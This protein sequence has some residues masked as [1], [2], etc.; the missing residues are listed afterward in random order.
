MHITM[1]DAISADGKL[2]RHGDPNLHA[3]T[4]S[5]DARHFAAMLAKHNLLVM[6]RN[7]YEVAHS[8][9]QAERLRVVITQN[10]QQYNAQAVKGQLE[11][12]DE[13]PQV[14]VQRLEAAG[15]KDML[16]LGGGNLNGQFV[17]AG[18]I[19]ELY[20][21][22]EPKLFG[23]GTELLGGQAVDQHLRLLEL[24][25]LN[26]EGTLLAHYQFETSAPA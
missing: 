7:T 9:P 22:I 25:K 20:L 17:A 23:T 21:T 2:T 19:T 3:W 24:T 16:L 5:E 11:F 1:I 4:S 26:N 12:T 8:R 14:L 6:G 13:T 18:L 10:P 15:Y